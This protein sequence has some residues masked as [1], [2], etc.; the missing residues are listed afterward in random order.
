[1]AMMKE[2]E[3]DDGDDEFLDYFSRDYQQA[4]PYVR[5]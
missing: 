5:R 1:M 2:I 4:S 3:D